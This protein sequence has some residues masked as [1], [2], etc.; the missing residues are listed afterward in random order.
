MRVE[1]RERG[2]AGVGREGVCVGG[3]QSMNR[4][5]GQGGGTSRPGVVEVWSGSEDLW[6]GL[7]ATRGVRGDRGPVLL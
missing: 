4:I 5:R 7:F 2:E 6:G 1:G 3:S